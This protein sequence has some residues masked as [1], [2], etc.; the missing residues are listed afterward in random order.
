MVRRVLTK[1]FTA[2]QKYL[3]ITMPNMGIRMQR[4]DNAIKMLLGVKELEKN[5][6]RRGMAYTQQLKEI[7]KDYSQ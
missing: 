6:N 4:N 7:F 2:T 3:S 5:F 1:N